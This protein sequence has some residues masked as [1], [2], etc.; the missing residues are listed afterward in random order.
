M[1]KEITLKLRRWFKRNIWWR[2]IRREA[3]S[4]PGAKL[5]GSDASD[6]ISPDDLGKEAQAVRFVWSAGFP[7]I[8]AGEKYWCVLTRND[9][10]AADGLMAR[11]FTPVKNGVI[12][13]M[14][15][16]LSKTGNPPGDLRLEV[17]TDK[18]DCSTKAVE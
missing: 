5:D 1:V 10:V 17:W 11:K 4:L 16:S 6:T 15:M 9:D 18:K 3:A 12:S 14:E 7:A 2:F 8:K 13:S